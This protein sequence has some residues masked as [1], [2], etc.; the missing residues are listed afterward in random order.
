MGK[1][2]YVVKKHRIGFWPFN[3]L[4]ELGQRT[5]PKPQ[6]FSVCS[7]IKT[8]SSLKIF[9]TG[10]ILLILKKREGGWEPAPEPEVHWFLNFKMKN[11]E[12]VVINK[13]KESHKTH[14][15]TPF[16]EHFWFDCKF[17][18]RLGEQDCQTI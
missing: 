1:D 18:G 7:F 2:I 16:P 5:Y 8:A 9:K 6:A 11:L 4:K 17:S 3:N 12:Q 13:I 10:T 15:W 14:L